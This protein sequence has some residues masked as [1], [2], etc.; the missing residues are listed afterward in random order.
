MLP[1]YFLFLLSICVG[2]CMWKDR[3]KK[4]L[5]IFQPPLVS[6]D[7]DLEKE[8]NIRHIRRQKTAC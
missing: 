8:T 5:D 3:S 4:S 7:P 1:G 2:S 6:G